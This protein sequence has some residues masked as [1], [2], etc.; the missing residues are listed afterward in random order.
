[1]EKTPLW[2]GQLILSG[3]VDILDLVEIA[4][5]MVNAVPGS[6]TWMNNALQQ[7][8]PLVFPSNLRA[9]EIPD[10]IAGVC[11][12]YH[13][14]YQWHSRKISDGMHGQIWIVDREFGISSHFLLDADGEITSDAAMPPE[15][16]DR[17]KRWM[18]DDNQPP[19]IR[20]QSAHAL[21]AL[22]AN[23]EHGASARACIA[24]RTK[25]AAGEAIR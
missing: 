14:S 9:A 15:H 5:Q 11:D 18:S 23:P 10:E 25:R 4:H 3:V 12:A 7:D 8:P 22:T 17:I 19:L 16:H 24:R 2:H 6:G 21:L 13:L 20:V 1:M